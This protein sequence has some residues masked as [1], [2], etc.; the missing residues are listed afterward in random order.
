[1][2]LSKATGKAIG[3]VMRFPYFT[4][5]VAKM[6]GWQLYMGHSL[7]VVVVGLLAY[8]L[9]EALRALGSPDKL[10]KGVKVVESVAAGNVS[11]STGEQIGSKVF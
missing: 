11:A 10:I 7:F 4:M 6:H 1:M 9:V 2:K 8:L 5:P 3:E